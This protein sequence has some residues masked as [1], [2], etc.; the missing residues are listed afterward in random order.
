MIPD[1]CWEIL[2]DAA[3]NRSP[4]KGLTH[5]FY[6]YPA[7][8]SP[9]FCATAIELF[10]KVSDVVYDPYMGGGTTVLEAMARGRLAIGSDVNT[11]AVFVTKVK[12]TLLSQPE[13]EAIQ[14]WARRFIPQLKYDRPLSLV[15]SVTQSP[16]TRNLNVKRA[17]FI[18]KILGIGLSTLGHLSSENSRLFLRCALLRTAQWAL[19][20]R[21]THASLHLFRQ[22]LDF[23]IGD[24]LNGMTELDKS[25]SFLPGGSRKPVLIQ[26]DAANIHDNA[27]FAD[28]YRRV[29]LVVTSPPYPGLHV[30]YH[31][32]QV[33][34]RKETP[35]PYWIIDCPD[36]QGDAHYN[37]GSRHQKHLQSYFTKSLATLRA[38][39]TVMRPGAY[40][41]QMI[42]F[43]NVEEYLPPY[44]ANMAAAG[45]QEVENAKGLFASVPSRIWRDVPNRKWHA[46]QK[47]KTCGSR[48]VVLIHR[49]L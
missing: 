4:V 33:D 15:P 49:A 46:A 26:G 48:E 31:R 32:W 12:T 21:R 16:Y 22:R 36:G 18:K 14:V 24:M 25:L 2:A 43:S 44:L 7:R 38:I 3:G 10:S 35:A 9:E 45:F 6:R 42:A 28:K 5:N 47:G 1:K 37:F 11:L 39:R 19:D 17:R 23:H 34:G 41:V 40:M 29:D 13:R 27:F 30:L 8:F 20:G